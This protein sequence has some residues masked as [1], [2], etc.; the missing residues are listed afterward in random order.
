MDDERG[1]DTPPEPQHSPAGPARNPAQY[2]VNAGPAG[3]Q[4]AL[5]VAQRLRGNR[6]RG[7]PVSAHDPTPADGECSTTG[8]RFDNSRVLG[9]MTGSRGRPAAARV[10]GEEVRMRGAGFHASLVLYLPRD[11]AG[12]RL[13]R[14]VTDTALQ[15]LDVSDACRYE[16]AVA[17]TEACGNVI[18]HA[19]LT[20]EYQ[21]TITIADH[22]CVIEVTDSGVG[23][24]PPDPP[25][26][27][28]HTAQ[29][30][31]GLFIIAQLT[32]QFQLDSH[33]HRGTTVR[34]TKHLA[35][36]Q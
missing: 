31:R 20:D 8:W 12:V 25:A 36:T 22:A 14:L 15:A 10:G 19:Q 27:P 17:L 21:V 28:D 9:T 18:A 5:S 23:F 24:T 1:D 32:D 4:G 26:R 6:G 33:P 29:S 34:F 2:A 3:T 7:N 35:Y 16:I 11:V 13:V 30:G